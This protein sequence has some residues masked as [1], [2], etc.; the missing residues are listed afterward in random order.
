MIEIIF[1]IISIVVGIYIMFKAI[2][3]I[4]KKYP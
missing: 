4:D 3:W 1:V 2:K